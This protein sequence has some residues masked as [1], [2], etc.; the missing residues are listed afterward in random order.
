MFQYIKQLGDHSDL[1]F[2]LSQMCKILQPSVN[3]LGY[4]MPELSNIYL[5]FTN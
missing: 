1:I 4:E 2:L 5:G 3:Q